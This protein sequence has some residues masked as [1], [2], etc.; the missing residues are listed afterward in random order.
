[1]FGGGPGGDSVNEQ[2]N[3]ARLL[4]R[5][6]AFSMVAARCSAADAQILR[7]VRDE[8]LYLAI[9]RDWDE[10][11]SSHLHMC[12][13]NAN[14]LIGLL[15][16]FGPQYFEI[17]QL[18]RISPETYRAIAPS[19]QDGALL[20]DGEAIALIPENAEKVAAAVAELRK[21]IARPAPDP[22]ASLREQGDALVGR[23]ADAASSSSGQDRLELRKA[24]T[25]VMEGLTRFALSMPL[26]Y[27]PDRSNYLRSI[28]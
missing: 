14:R 3:L 26:R 7:Q 10:F 9:A 16:E 8:K 4:G 1:M 20:K 12:R 15:N 22:I 24:L 2:L 27:P 6:E 17:A 13:A 5:R 19:I 28:Y 21:P 25:H 18:T 23:F 11:C